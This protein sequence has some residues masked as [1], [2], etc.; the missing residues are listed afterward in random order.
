MGVWKLLRLR[1][2]PQLGR[3]Y[4]PAFSKKRPNFQGVREGGY[5]LDW[6]FRGYRI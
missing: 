3:S 2:N 5:A 6:T 4:E 1:P